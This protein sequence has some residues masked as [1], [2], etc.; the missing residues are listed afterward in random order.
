MIKKDLASTP[1]TEKTTPIASALAGEAG[2][3]TAEGDQV[4]EEGENKNKETG[5]K[6]GGAKEDEEDEEDVSSKTQVMVNISSVTFVL[7][8]CLSINI[9]RQT[10][11]TVDVDRVSGE[12]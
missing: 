2:L 1:K 4:G 11:F 7:Q 6:P 10:L 3:D 5:S 9:L 8:R 12:L